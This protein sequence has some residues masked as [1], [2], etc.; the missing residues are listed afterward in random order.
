[1]RAAALICRPSLRTVAD[2]LEARAEP[3]FDQLPNRLELSVRGYLR[4]QSRIW[5]VFRERA[6]GFKMKGGGAGAEHTGTVPSA[7]LSSGR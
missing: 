3:S 4:R 2:G 6:Q 1:M 7:P 5:R